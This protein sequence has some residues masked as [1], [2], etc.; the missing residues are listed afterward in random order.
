VGIFPDFCFHE[1]PRDIGFDGERRWIHEID[2]ELGEV[3]VW[4]VDIDPGFY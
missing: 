3:E 1:I 4:I 2:K